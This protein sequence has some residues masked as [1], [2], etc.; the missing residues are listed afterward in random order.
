[1]AINKYFKSIEDA[2][3]YIRSVAKYINPSNSKIKKNNDLNG[4]TLVVGN[5]L[6]YQ[7]LNDALVGMYNVKWI[8][9]QLDLDSPNI[10]PIRK[11]MEC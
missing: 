4:L 6:D 5:K 2:R 3:D 10:C 1:M 11:Q 8:R 9:I 7:I